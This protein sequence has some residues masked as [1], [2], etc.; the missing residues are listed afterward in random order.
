MLDADMKTFLIMLLRIRHD[1]S[2][3][4]GRS[5]K[6]RLL[7]NSLMKHANLKRIILITVY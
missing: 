4:K 7:G 5:L 2:I 3:F 1:I 6:K